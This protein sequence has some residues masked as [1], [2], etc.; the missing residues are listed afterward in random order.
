M[1]IC[2]LCLEEKKLIKAHLI[3]DSILKRINGENR[4]HISAEL[5]N[6]D[7]HKTMQG[8]YWDKDILCQSCDNTFS[9]SEQ[10]FLSFINE[11]VNSPDEIIRTPD[12]EILIY[13]DIDETKFRLFPLITLWRLAISKTHSG[14]GV[15]L[16]ILEEMV[17]DCVKQLNPG[18][19][20]FFPFSIYSFKDLNDGRAR[21]IGSALP[22]KINGFK[23]YI[24]PISD[25]IIVIRAGKNVSESIVSTSIRNN[26]LE[27]IN[28]IG[29]SGTIFLDAMFSSIKAFPR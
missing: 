25:F 27:I 9:P 24:L 21:F 8:G 6:L 1:A 14:E 11:R 2:K 20:D 19:Y 18:P 15:S 4:R 17:Y 13:N 3:S 10:Y 29:R 26:R 16:G 22:L 23:Y 28:L 12:G 7:N 5:H